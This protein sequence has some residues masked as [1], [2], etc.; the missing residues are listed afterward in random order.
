MCYKVKTF[1]LSEY[2]YSLISSDH[3]NH[4]TRKLSFVET[5]YCR[6]DAFKY[7]FFPYTISERNK[8]DSELQNA[9]SHSI[10][11]KSLLKFGRPSPNLLYKIYDHLGVKL[12]TRFRIGSSHLDKNRFNHSFENWIHPLCS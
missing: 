2:L 8:L 6:N 1:Q 11:R 3:H 10:F 12:V 4:N 9:K 7:S 5:Y